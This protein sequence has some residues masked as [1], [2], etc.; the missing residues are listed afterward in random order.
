[1]Q[2]IA[3]K[4][5]ATSLC[6]SSGLVGGVYAPSLFMGAALGAS[7]GGFLAHMDSMSNLIQIKHPP[8]RL[9]VG[10]DGWRVGIRVSRA[11]DGNFVVV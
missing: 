11:F 8:R 6:R 7:Y 2:L 10:R 1:M 4:L 9:R 3:A 5:L